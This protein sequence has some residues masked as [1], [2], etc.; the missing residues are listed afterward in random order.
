MYALQ[1]TGPNKYEYLEMDRP[2]PN[3]F[4]VLIKVHRVGICGTDIEMLHG[5][6]PYFEMGWTSYPVILGHEW[7]GT[8]VE[9]GSAVSTLVPGD[10]ITGDVSI[11][12]GQCQSCMEGLYSLCDQRQEV[13][14]SRGKQGGFAQYMTMPAKHCYKLPE[15]VSLD[16]GSLVEP[17]ATVVRAIRK[18]HLHVGSSVYI[19]GDGPIGLLALQAAQAMGASQVFLGGTDPEKL[20]MAKKLGATHTI[21]VLTENVREKVM[22]LTQGRGSPLSVE[23]SGAGAALNQCIE[24]TRMGG[25]VS[26]IGVYD[27][28]IEKMNMGLVVVKDL[29]LCCSVASP[30]A[31]RHTLDMMNVGKIKVAPLVS[32]VFDLA[33]A[34]S[35]FEKQQ[36]NCAGRIKIQ[37]KPDTKE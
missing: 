6:M 14:L 25:K 4:E 27:K 8:I 1:L 5:T 29:D 31:F 3:E 24:V 35:A 10:R 32:D 7:S 36:S 34:G 17:T 20:A 30:N 9:V 12:C 19:A 2:I 37:L 22:D 23:A 26:V 33:D 18:A 21:N 16:D 28:P 11:G 13:G 15:N